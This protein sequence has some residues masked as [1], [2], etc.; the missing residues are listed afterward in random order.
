[1]KEFFISQYAFWDKV[2][3]Y[4]IDA[5]Q[6]LVIDI[7][8]LPYMLALGACIIELAVKNRKG[9]VW[10]ARV[11]AFVISVPFVGL[12]ITLYVLIKDKEPLRTGTAARMRLYKEMYYPKRETALN[13]R[14]R[15]PKKSKKNRE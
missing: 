15:R 3:G 9:I 12:L 14:K 1:M 11:I 5:W 13:M 7:V 10:L 2:L 8:L 4:P 6:V